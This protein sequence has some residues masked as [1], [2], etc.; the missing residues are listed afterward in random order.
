MLKERNIL[1][2]SDEAWLV[3]FGSLME[4]AEFDGKEVKVDEFV[5]VAMKH[6][7][8]GRLFVRCDGHTEIIS[9]YRWTVLCCEDEEEWAGEIAS[10]LLDEYRKFAARTVSPVKTIFDAGCWEQAEP[11]Y[12]EIDGSLERLVY[13][14]CVWGWEGMQYS[15]KTLLDNGWN[16][17]LSVERTKELWQIAYWYVAEGCMEA[18]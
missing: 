2:T 1:D 3:L 15:L 18:A 9:T 11:F 8:H 7:Y 17:G 14:N 12:H 16:Y 10:I 6:W 5:S 13:E 4:S